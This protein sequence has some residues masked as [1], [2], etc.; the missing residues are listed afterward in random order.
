[1]NEILLRLLWGQLQ[2]IGLFT[3]KD[4]VLV[5][6]KTNSG[7]QAL[8]HRWLEESIAVLTRNHY[9]TCDQ[10]TCTVQDPAPI[11][12]EAAWK[13]WDA[14]KRS[15]LED[16]NTKGQVTLVEA[17]LRALPDILTGKTPATNIMFPNSSTKMVEGV[18]KDNPVADYFNEILADIVISYLEERLSQDPSAQ[19]R[20]IEIGAGTGG[21]SATVFKKLKPYRDHIKEYC[22]TDISKAFLMHAEKEYGPDNPYLT[23]RIFDLGAPLAGQGIQAG[24]YDLTIAANVL[25]AT[26]NIR[27][28]LRNT[29]TTLKRNGLLLLNEISGN[30]LFTHLTFGLLEGWWLYEDTKLRIPGCPG[31]SPQTWQAVLED[32]GFRSVLFPAQEAH[33]LGQQ[34]IVAESDGIVRQKKQQK[35]SATPVKKNIEPR[36]GRSPISHKPPQRSLAQDQH[37]AIK[38]AS[39]RSVAV[40]DRMVEDHV[41]TI[42][43]ESISEALNMEEQRIQDDRSF[44]EYGVDSIIVV[45]LVNI[46]NKKCHIALPTTVV[47]DYNNVDQLTKYII[48]E[49]Y[50]TLISSLQENVPVLEKRTESHSEVIPVPIWEKENRDHNSINQRWQRNPFLAQDPKPYSVP[51]PIEKDTALEIVNGDTRGP[52]PKEPIAI[53]GMSGRF[54]GSKTVNDLWEHLSKGDDLIEEA[55]RWNFSEYYPEGTSYCKHGSFLDDI[56]WFDPLFFNISGQEATFMDPQ[57]RLFLEESWKALEDAGYAGVGVQGRL[58]GVYVGYAG[59]DY[60]Q[61]FSSNPPPQAFWGNAGSVVPARIAYYLDLQGPAI[62]VDTACSSSLVA[63]HLACQ[64]LWAGETELALAGGVFIQSTPD[65]YLNSNRAG[66]LSPT[67]RCHTFGERADG[68][69][70]GEGVGAVVLKRL[71]EAIADGDHIYGV[72]RGSGINQDGTTNGITAPSANS[73]ERLERYVYDTFHIHPEQIQ[74]VEA[75]GTGTKLGD[76]IEYQALTRSFRAYTDKQEY[77]AIG[78]IKSN[79]G[80]AAAAAGIAGIIKILLSLQHKQIPPSLHFQSGNPHIQFKD[81]PF[82]VNLSLKDWDVEPDS[83]RCAVTSSF[84]FSGT[85][86]HMAIEEAPKIE[87]RHSEKPG[88]LIVL[89]ARTSEQLRQQA[90]QLLAYC[91]REPQ[92]DFGNMSYTLLLGRKHFNHRLAYIVR[93]QQELITLLNKWL[94]KGKVSQIYVSELHESDR[95]EQPALKRYGN[96]CI[97]NCH[98]ASNASDYLEHLST[99]ADLYVQGYELDF[100]Q[101][102]INELYSK[103]PLPTYPFARER[104]WV[105]ESGTTTTTTTTPAATIHPLLH[106]NTSDLA[107]QRFTSTFTGQEFFLADHTINGQHL[108]PRVAY[109]EMARAAVQQATGVLEEDQTG[110]L[111]KNVEWVRPIAVGKQPVKVHIGLFPED[112]GEIA[113]EIYSESEEAGAE[114]VVHSQGIVVLSTAQEAPTLDLSALQAECSQAALSSNQCYAAF[115]SIGIDYGPAHQGIE[116]LY[117]GQNQALA[118][119]T[120]PPS[121]SATKDQFVLHPSLMDASSQASIGFVM[122]AGDSILSGGTASLKPALPFALEE[123]E[124]LG[125]CTSTM[126]ALVRFGDGSKAGDKVQKLDIALCDEHGH[127]CVRMKGLQMQENTENLLA[128]SLEKIQPS[129]PVSQTQEPFELMTFEEIWQEQTLPEPARVEIKTMVCFLSNPAYQQA[130]ID[131]I[132]ALDQQVRIIFISQGT[133]Y[134]KHSQQMYS[135]SPV[136]QNT[137][138]DAFQSIREEYGNVDAILYLWALEDKRHIQDISCIVHTLQAITSAKLNPSRLL[139]AAQYKSALERCYL[140]SWIG[141]ER[142]LGLVLPNTQVAL[143]CQEACEQSQEIA[144]KDWLQKLWAELQTYK[145]QSVLYQEGRRHVCQIRPISIQAG[146]SL[147]RS[148]GAYLITGGCGGLGFLFAQHIA[149]I[150]PV[151]LILTGRSAIDD[152]KQSKI[153]ALEDLGSRILYIQADVCDETR[154][155]AELNRAKEHFGRIHGVI[156]A[157]GI[158]GNQSIL[159][160]EIQSFTKVLEPKIK[161]TLVLDDLLQEEPLDFICYFS[162]SSAILGDF[163]SCDYAIGNRFLMAYAHY[164]NYQKRQGKAIVINWPLWRDGGMGV[165]DD[166]TTKMYL[167]SSGQRFLEAEE[168]V[169]VFDRILSQGNAQYLVLVGQRSRVHRFLGLV[170]D[171][172]ASLSPIISGLTGKGRRA[173]MKGLSLAECLEW[174]LKEHT[175]KLLKISRDKLDAEDNLA[176]FGF[177]SISLAEFATLLTSHY[178]IEITPALFFQYSTLAKLTQYFLTGHQETIREFYR[179]DVLEKAVSQRVSS[180]AVAPRPGAR[181]SRFKI[182]NTTQGVPEP[183]AIIGMSGRFPD[184]RNIDEM[185]AILTQG[186]D[187]VKEIPA[188]RFAGRGSKW[189]CG[190]LPGVSEFDPLF[191]EISPKE[192]ETMDPKQRL[193]LQESW[194]ALEDAGYGATKIETSKIGMFVGVEEGQYRML[195]KEESNITANHNAILAARLSYFLNLSGP[196]MAINTACSSGLVAGHQACLSLRNHECDTAIAAGVNLL[197]LSEMF[198]ILNQAG[199]LSE[200]SRCYAFDKRANGMVPGEAVAAVVLKRL[201]QA[202]ADGDQIYAV[203]KGSSLNYDGKTNGITAPSGSSQTQL[204]KAVYEQYQVNPEEIEYIVTHGTGTKLGDPIE[205]NALYDAF[206]DY[207]K[208][209]C[210][211]ALT[212]TKTNFGHTFAASGLVSLISLVQALRHETIPASL[213]CEQENDYINWKESPF[214]V[215]KASKPWPQASVKSRTGAVS[216]FGMSGTNAH[217]VVQSYAPEEAGGFPEQAPFFLLA[218]SAKTEEALQEKIKDMITVL[219]KKDLHEKDLLQISYTLLEGRQHFN[220]RSAIVIQDREDAVYVWQQTGGK[221]RLPN[222]FQGKVPRDFKGQKVMQEY[223]Q[224]LIKQSRSLK[225]HKNKYQEILYALAD[226]YCQG[227]DLPWHQLFGDT[228]PRCISLPTYPFARERYWVPRIDTQHGDSSAVT[229][230]MAASIHPLLHQ[231]TSDFSEQRFTSTFTGKEFFL[232]DHVIKGQLVLPGVAYLEMARAA[233]EQATG[234]LEKDQ[235]D[236]RLKNVVWVRP[237]AVGE[238]PVKVHIGL[239]PEESGEIAF[240]IYSQSAEADAEPVVHSQG[241]AMLSTVERIPPMDLPTL[242]AQCSQCT[243]SPSQCYEAFKAMGLQYGPGHQGI[244]MMYVGSGQVLAKLSLPSTVSDTIEQFVLHPSLLDSA[245][246]ALIGLIMGSGDT[247]GKATLK[248]FLPFALQELEIL[249][250]CTPTMWALIRSGV[251]SK[252]GDK[253]QK[254][255][256]DLC[257]GQGNVCIR[258]KE[259]SSRVLEGEVGS[260]GAEATLGTL[261]LH[262]CWKEQAIAQAAIVPDHVQHVVMLCEPNNI[263]RRIIETQINGV[264]CLTLESKHEGIGERFQDYATQVFKEIQNILKD[265]P[266]SNVL[267]Q[268]VVPAQ[269]EQQ[270]FS[271]LSGILKTGQ[272]ENP[273]LIGQLIEVEPGEDAEGI[274]EKLQENSQSIMNNHVRYQDGKRYVA[275]LSEV[276]AS[277]EAVKIPWKERGVYLITGGAGGLGLIFAKEIAHKVKDATLVLTGRSPLNRK[278]QA[279]LKELQD[280]GARVEYRQVDVTQ[281]KAVVNLIQSIQADL[282]GINGIIHSAGVI[283][284][285]FILKKTKDELLEVLA[286]KVTGLVYLDQASKELPLDFFILFSSGAGVV[287]NPGQADYA[288]ANAFMDA[289]AKYRNALVASNQRHGQT[290]SINWPLWQDGGMGVDAETEKMMRQNTGMVAMQTSTGIRALYQGLASGQDRVMVMEGEL[291]RLQAVLLGQQAGTAALKASY[292]IEENKAVPVIDQDSLQ[293]KAANYFKKLLSSVINL[294]THRIEADAPLEKYGIDSIMVM[295]LTNQLEKTFGSLPKTLFFEYQNIK[296]LTAYF[297]ENYR[298]RLTELWGIEDKATAS[299]GNPQDFAVAT[300]AEK[301]DA[302]SRRRPRF[303]SLRVET[304]EEKEALDIAIIGV[305]GRYPQAGNIRA[306]WENL[307]DGKDCITEIPKDRWDH[308]LYFDEDKNKPGKIYSKWGGFINGVDQFDPLF[309]NISPR[310][311]QIMDPQERLFLQC[312]YETLED[313]GYTREALG[314]N[315]D[316]GLGGNVGVYVGV[317]YEEYQLYGAQE[318]IQGRPVA[319]SG[320]P[321]SIANR[322]SYFCNFHGPS[323]A[324]DTMCSSSLTAIHLACQSL[325]QGGCEVA[326]A[327]GI[328]VSIHPNKYLMLSQ[329]KF[330][331]SKGRCESF[332]QGGDGYVPGEGVGAVLLKPLAKAVADGDHIYGMIKATAINHGGK[333]NGYTVPNPNAQASVIGRAFKVAGIDPRTISYIEAHGTGT[334]LGD[335]IEITGLSKTFQAYTKDKQ[336]CAIGSAKSNIGHCESAAGI[337]GV[338]KVLLQLK[339]RQLVPSLHSEVLNPNIDFASTPFIVQQELAE[340]KR[341]VIEKGGE[342]KEYPRIAG[343][344]SFGAGGANAHVVIEEYIP[345]DLAQPPI[346]ISAGNQAI[347]VLS[348][349]NEERLREQV[350]QLLAAIQERQFTDSELADM[351]YTLQVGREAMEERLAVVAGSIKELEEKLKSYVDGRDDIGDLYRGQVKRNKETLDVFAADEDMSR[352]IDAWIA[353]GKYAKLIDLWVKG[354]VFDWN[355][356]YGNTKP[357]RISMPTYPFAKER[358]WLFEEHNKAGSMASPATLPSRSEDRSIERVMCYLQKQWELCSATSTPILNRTVAILT[359]QETMEL[360]IQLSQHFPKSQILELHD[361][362]SQLQQPEKH[363]KNYDGCVDLIGCGKERNELPNWMAWL[364]R[365]TENGHREG[366]MMLCVTKG[367]ES[368]QNTAVNLSGASGAGL[369]RMLQSEYGHL[370]SRHMDAD[371]STGDQALAQQ[372]ASEFFMESEDIEICYRDGKRYRAYLEEF[373]KGDDSDR[374]LE[375]PDGHVL[376]ITGGTRGI[377]YLCAQHFVTNYGVRRLVLTGRETMPPREEWDAYQQQN[378]SVAQKIQAI[379]ALEAQGAKVQVLSVPL[380]DEH[381]V[382]KSLQEI[383]N[384]MGPIG[385]IIHCAGTDGMK[386]PAFIRKSVRE[387]Q[388]VL[389]PKV[390]GLDILYQSFNNEPLQF[391]VLFSSVSG[392]IPALASGQSDYAMANAY[393]D[394]VAEAKTHASPIISIQWPSWKETGM[395]EVKSRVYQQ[396][397]LLSHTNQEGLQLLDQILSRKIGPVVLPAVVNP[398]LWKPHQLMQRRKQET[399]AANIQTRHSIASESLKASDA[400]LTA[401]QTWLIDLFSQELKMDPSK[402]E[403]DIPF[404]DYGVDSVLLAQLLRSINQ[405]LTYD[406]DPSIL[407]EYSTIESLAA[408]LVSNHASSLSK[409]LE[410]MS[411]EPYGPPTEDSSPATA[412]TSSGS[413]EGRGLQ[414]GSRIYRTSKPS[415]IAVIGLSCRFPGAN[416]LEEY[417][418]LLSQ[419][420]SAIRSVPRERW[421][422]LNNFYAGLIDNITQFDAKFFLIPENDVRAMDP[423]A[424]MVLEETLKLW[425]HAGYSHQEIKGKQVGVYLGGRSQHRPDEAIV[426]QALNPIVTVGQNYLAANISQF[427]DL[428][429][430]S[431]IVDTACSSALVGMNMA[432]QALNNGE[433]ESAI[434]GGV[435]LLNTDDSHRLFQQRGILNS[436]PFFHIFDQRSGGVVLGEGVGMVLLKTVDQALEDGDHI[437]AVIK[438]LAINNDGRTAGPATPNLHA[439]KEVLQTA[440]ARSGRKPEEIIYIE[441]NGSGSQVT[442]LLELKAIQ[443]VYRSSNTSPL[444]LGSVKPNIGHPLCAE[445]IASFIKV[446]LMLQYEQFVPFLSGEQSMT[447]YNIESSPFYF[448]R[449]LTKW[450]NTPRIAAINCF[451]DGG[452]NAHVIL[453]AWED[454]ASRPVKRHPNPPPELNRQ[455]FGQI[456]FKKSPHEIKTQDLRTNDATSKV[457]WEIFN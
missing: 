20:I 385:G 114:P 429:G 143:I 13:E 133:S 446:V 130:A 249:S 340:W 141:F 134:Q 250:R 158:E 449:K 63:V 281:E 138:Q 51:V 231:N 373:E 363:W 411:S 394:Y 85:N 30:A 412:S 284:D 454:P 160:K 246:Q 56:D 98:N 276:E 81:S 153:K 323:M 123:L 139:L 240:E 163:G 447:H 257:D 80:H 221:E 396:T 118:K 386:N 350:Q 25:H 388:Q 424:L 2:S 307:R 452:T 3:E 50:S 376:W 218:L 151:N 336:F 14:K 456:D 188:D 418:Q 217:M 152:E 387:I 455:Q 357:C 142:S 237:I 261:M 361:L 271:G 262:H 196:N 445:G 157:A 383:K 395:G 90:E 192:A 120:L 435:S 119:L 111:L 285:N 71:K 347:I 213:H 170:K 275:G 117:I 433:I 103:I 214:Y 393:M 381:A 313:A 352:L 199:M 24:G 339:N 236:I 311:A 362:E 212:S 52:L 377:G 113:F 241:S 398:D 207:T 73:Q 382:Q 416:T 259:F 248:P 11:D 162:S 365:L 179:E 252:A 324:V 425:Y 283:R 369:Y 314:F 77:C 176:D 266:T 190:L 33:E 209:Q 40:T 325:Q 310:E 193:L 451:A 280:L 242:Q 198:E 315:Q 300:K 227:Y 405:L 61:L 260:V 126:W 203:I 272:L 341:P 401:T 368:Y 208:K 216:A 228:K 147:L 165:K 55:S 47:F 371:P 67:G 331:S 287:G 34:I 253:V 201:S 358:Y 168:G 232:A 428:R 18:Y 46:I 392:I 110:I 128:T 39:P 116:Q 426:R 210:Y 403:V 427:F 434:V 181:K 229:S 430:P 167:K 97:Q 302:G 353:K 66:M 406:L 65:F 44:S 132:Q 72:I 206:K 124:I 304:R 105:P 238:Q 309:F 191:F 150:Q 301:P 16:P 101:L 7:L 329:G 10:E 84:G 178:G 177:D 239:Y 384:T 321:A 194:K 29:K 115:R 125:N 326:I 407:F 154:M 334:S 78:S 5:D 258:M 27:H 102:F 109:L 200:D 400:L 438:A 305:S 282:G 444:I 453:E 197:F 137:Y 338:T 312:V 333:T 140:E 12:M 135:I 112:S 88:Y 448:Y 69:V 389:D 4:S 64:G 189:K 343:I 367:L 205:I 432:I 235:T 408:W 86:A 54:A 45:N 37:L 423:Q 265:K 359:T 439:Q 219:Q 294:P 204:L 345:K 107:E 106:Q 349:K 100:K 254:L 421:G 161:G 91:E 320:N 49:H 374:T 279:E 89:S 202:K 108:L 17:T 303:A 96:E 174:D 58:C 169:A 186:Q 224:G 308:S 155:K 136:D 59:G 68:F 99:I 156:H 74:M 9:L 36:A 187:V 409:I 354:L 390:A 440:L 306:F 233:V 175:S 360:A 166:E 366:L 15:W 375:F 291:K 62:A 75:H 318:Q 95:R 43:K 277:Q 256:I 146:K 443:S 172:A 297:L 57:Q 404:Q 76:P 245:L 288:A 23:Y 319:V 391:F 296:D 225:E 450:T 6:L 149:K 211:C 82:Y 28:T 185:W 270:L 251:G 441:A 379:R 417:W 286:P 35:P 299:A 413:S 222:L 436:E 351:A 378:T 247:S 21:T 41:R 220:H 53:I 328:N 419:G 278:K 83:T 195:L 332:G 402:L 144:M 273:K 267:I 131:A 48:R 364:Q 415:D 145:A 410:P 322:V 289:Y 244:E 164:R 92:A 1:M 180:V 335:P 317:M 295:Q 173:E 182:I 330:A 370:R 70:P 159:E 26:R 316:F 380:T 372:I 268:V 346:T 431:I 255:D 356:L 171:Q 129:A 263:S 31:L 121:V 420:R 290:L 342:I 226:L 399:F 234:V 348:A 437:Y 293:E 122:S 93:S 38:K 230:V 442:D 298:D 269:G 292:T 223:A 127:V 19:I 87:R 355:R 397:G 94:Q 32:E 422:Y 457:I 60:Q 215:N 344:S 243:L 183:I 327:G 104:Y 274:I 8:Y 148:E 42:I 337:A 414:K 264:R 22:Y 79:L 184:A